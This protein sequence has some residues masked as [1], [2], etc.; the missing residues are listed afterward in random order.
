[1][2]ITVKYEPGRTVADIL[3]DNDIKTSHSVV[4][5]GRVLDDP[6][7]YAPLPGD[8]LVI[9]HD[10]GGDNPI[11][12]I[13]MIAVVVTAAVVAPWAVGA[14]GL[15]GMA[16]TVAEVALFSTMVAAG[17]YIVNQ[18][19][20]VMPDAPE[21]NI[22]N[23]PSYSFNSGNPTQEGLTVPI[24][25]GRVKIK[26]PL[27]SS[28]IDSS[29]NFGGGDYWLELTSAIPTKYNLYTNKR[30][31]NGVSLRYLLADHE[32]NA[33]EDITVN[34]QSIKSYINVYDIYRN[35]YASHGG[36]SPGDY[37]IS[38]STH[39]KCEYCYSLGNGEM[40][41][42][43]IHPDAG[44][45]I[46][47]D[48]AHQHFHRLN[49]FAPYIRPYAEWNF[50]D[51]EKE[52]LVKCGSDPKLDSPVFDKNFI[53]QE[54]S[55]TDI[56]TPMVVEP[57]Q[58]SGYKNTG[59]K[60]VYIS[61]SFPR[62][63]RKIGKKGET[64]ELERPLKI[65]FKVRK[66]GGSWR[67]WGTVSIN[68]A[69]ES[70]AVQFIGPFN[71]TYTREE[72]CQ[73][74]YTNNLADPQKGRLDV[75]PDITEPFEIG[76]QFAERPDNSHGGRDIT[77]T[78]V[79]CV[80]SYF[81]AP[82][83]IFP[84]CSFLDLRL[85][86]SEVAS[87]QTP[88]AE[89]ILRGK[90]NNPARQVLD[91]Y[92][93]DEYG[94]GLSENEIDIDA[95][96][97]WEDFCTDK[98]ITSNFV[99]ESQTSIADAV[100]QIYTLGRAYPLKVGDKYTVRFDDTTRPTQLFNEENIIKDSF[101]LSYLPSESKANIFC[102]KYRDA[103]KNF[104]QTH[105]EYRREEVT[106]E[107]RVEI[108]LNNCTDYQT[109][110]N[111]LVYMSNVNAL[112]RKTVKFDSAVNSINASVGDVIQIKYRGYSWAHDSCRIAR[113]VSNAEYEVTKEIEYDQGLEYIALVTEEPAGRIR[114]YPIVSKTEPSTTLTFKQA[115][116]LPTDTTITIGSRG[117]KGK[118]F[119]IIALTRKDDNTRTI[120]G[121][122][123]DA[124][125]YDGDI[126]IEPLPI[127]IDDN[128]PRFLEVT[129][130]E[131]G[132]DRSSIMASWN[133]YGGRNV[134]KILN[135]GDALVDQRVHSDYFI[136]DPPARVKPGTKLEFIIAEEG[137]GPKYEDQQTVFK[138]TGYPSSLDL[139]I[140]ITII[141]V[142][143]TGFMIQ[144]DPNLP[145]F[146]K[147]VSVIIRYQSS[148][149]KPCCIESRH[150]VA[151]KIHCYLNEQLRGTVYD[152]YI[153]G[154]TDH[155]KHS[156]SIGQVSYE[157][158][159]SSGTSDRYD[160]NNV[161]AEWIEGDVYVDWDSIENSLNDGELNSLKYMVT[162][163]TLSGR[164]LRE[165]SLYKNRYI[166]RLSDNRNDSYTPNA[167]LRFEIMA[168]NTS[169]G[170]KSEKNG[171]VQTV[172]PVLSPTTVDFEYL[173]NALK[174]HI[175]P[176]DSI[177]YSHY[178]CSHQANVINETPEPWT[179]LYEM[180]REYV[181]TF[182]LTMD[183]IENG[184][185]A[186]YIRVKVVDIF[187]RETGYVEIGDTVAVLSADMMDI[188]D[189]ALN[190]SK[191]FVK[192]P[193]LEADNWFANTPG[194]GRISWNEHR[195]FYFGKQFNI[196]AGNT[197]K[198]YVYFKC[199]DEVDFENRELVE[200]DCA[201][202]SVEEHPGDSET[203]GDND[204]IIATNTDGSYDL[205]WN[206]IAN[207]I[208]GSANI[209]HAAIKNAHIDELSA[210]KITSGKVDDDRLNDG[211]IDAGRLST[212][213][214]DS[215]F[216][217][218]GQ[219]WSNQT[220]GR[221]IPTLGPGMA[222][223]VAEGVFGANCLR[224]SKR[225]PYCSR[226][227][228]PVKPDSEFIFEVRFRMHS[229]TVQGVDGD[230]D[231]FIAGVICLDKDFTQIAKTGIIFRPHS[232]NDGWITI[233]EEF[234]SLPA[235]TK[236]IRPFF[237]SHED[238]R[239][240]VKYS[241]V[242]L[243][244]CRDKADGNSAIVDELRE[245]LEAR[246]N[247]IQQQVDKSIS[248]WFLPCEPTLYNEPASTWGDN[249]E[250]NRHLGDLYYNTNTG[251]AYRFQY[252]ANVY[253]WNRI[254][255][256]DVVTALEKANQAKDVADTKVRAFVAQPGT[257]YEVGDMWLEGTNGTIKRCKRTR[258]TG[259]FAASDWERASGDAYWSNMVNDNGRM[260]ADYADNTQR[261]INLGAD[262]SNAKANGHTLIQGG[263]INADIIK[264]DES[265]IVG[266]LPSNLETTEGAQEKANAAL[267]NAITYTKGWSKQGADKTQTA[268]NNGASIAN[269]KVNGYT[270]IQ[271]GYIRS[272]FLSASR[273]RTG[274]LTSHDGKLSIN[275][276]DTT[277]G[278][279]LNG[280][281]IRIN[282]GNANVLTITPSVSTF[283]GV[284][285]HQANFNPVNPP[286]GVYN[287]VCFGNIQ[288]FDVYADDI[289]L[290]VCKGGRCSRF[291]FTHSGIY[292]DGRLIAE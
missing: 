63:L 1:M 202:E 59:K 76:V 140:G 90:T 86:A 199:P 254:T 68:G 256:T 10:L 102:L 246:F 31:V 78:Y 55:Q 146:I 112:C 285:Y 22:K 160:I 281:A 128:S 60:S 262:I 229:S 50:P 20:G 182:S 200:F 103:Q 109:A 206:A 13:A 30:A 165:V 40:R 291:T 75:F 27:V 274:V 284:T 45:Y 151:E 92:T 117:R 148:S 261:V 214:I 23:T 272:D 230:K 126:P 48:E 70:S 224:F 260:P 193:V 47:G 168:I 67:E 57:L 233:K 252:A 279:T 174:I 243:V 51:R 266:H 222:T 134:L 283:E 101:S 91:I 54:L 180:T 116:H 11:A 257:P 5:N 177:Y 196:S 95:F 270:L 218:G 16:A 273:I 158:G 198:R 232:I 73:F 169:T 42:S 201:Y 71:S 62:G 41:Y 164:V 82:L 176:V 32:I 36:S 249:E 189:F 97:E 21:S 43:L 124:R 192:I 268:L 26:P 64:Y 24:V 139:E 253:K 88:V 223:T 19:F 35:W 12:A 80:Y 263:Y 210:D 131:L 288:S 130:T 187:L 183:E 2:N 259:S 135:G 125:M 14:T 204:F 37:L 98:G 197:D 96:E 87:G 269:A 205:A 94:A 84:G 172:A 240:G 153:S 235:N 278:I 175:A 121:L 7:S 241:D 209:M 221:S 56:G 15:T 39:R 239:P 120:T 122:E 265:L 161:T 79:D 136:Y 181:H 242:D 207:Q 4:V 150:I 244:R 255:D 38:Q 44:I 289:C 105:M 3:A 141:P 258:L 286:A 123:Y 212:N 129:E 65:K 145:A 33:I 61:F 118:L 114:E 250:K 52:M 143:N 290:C 6:L 8:R 234:A 9:A 245:Q 149:G 213:Y 280:S 178:L 173:T 184:Y 211:I 226:G 171:F 142:N 108:T 237:Q 138:Y 282:N 267:S 215:N 186:I 106:K 167:E 194:P 107:N 225:V 195:L 251:Y 162:V 113:R 287:S 271:G 190:A 110:K 46:P 236:Y 203:L 104:E 179:A 28:I 85:G 18:T 29:Q 228:L 231:R 66:K 77:T 292:K 53:K 220:F 248:T 276:S 81:S 144:F 111:H 191:M 89:V 133:S 154:M 247:A 277:K 49:C 152:F 156:Y 137:K 227:V 217:Y 157:A 25:Y 216:D 127:V 275:L 185:K 170:L 238:T 147:S 208:I 83:Q 132:A 99:I 69:T 155:D 93:N 115:V 72:L 58:Q 74:L 264:I 188:K 17:G 159:G 219:F 100:A 166:Y 119:R 34:K 163:S